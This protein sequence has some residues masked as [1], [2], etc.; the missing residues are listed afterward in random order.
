MDFTLESKLK[1]G[2][3]LPVPAKRQQKTIDNKATSRSSKAGLQFPVG[4]VHRH[5]KNGRYAARIGSSA[6]V[7]LAA[8]LEYLT[9]DILE[10]ADASRD[11]KAKRI[12]PRH[13]QLAVRHD[14][15]LGKILEH[16]TIR[17]GGVLPNLH[18][19][20]RPK[21][22]SATSDLPEQPVQQSQIKKRK[23]AS[24]NASTEDAAQTKELEVTK[25]KKETTVRAQ[26][27]PKKETKAMKNAESNDSYKGNAVKIYDAYDRQY[28]FPKWQ[29]DVTHEH[30]YAWLTDNTKTTLWYKGNEEYAEQLLH[31]REP[32]NI[33]MR[34]HYNDD[35]MWENF[36]YANGVYQNIQYRE[37]AKI[38]VSCVA[39][40]QYHGEYLSVNVIN[41]I[42]LAL[43]DKQQPD[44]T[45]LMEQGKDD[46]EQI[47]RDH[48][49]TMW[50]F[51]FQDATQ[52]KLTRIVY[53]HV[54]GG[55]FSKLIN[56]VLED[57]EI[58]F[59]EGILL[60][61]L[62]KVKAKKEAYSGIELVD[63][64]KAKKWIPPAIFDNSKNGERGH[65]GNT[66]YVNAWD[67]WSIVGN[68]NG[69]DDS[70]DGFWGRS[71]D[72]AMRCWPMA[73]PNIDVCK[74][75]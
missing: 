13:I 55:A 70:L 8:V 5:L 75:K 71:S 12:T 6:P 28:A 16:V 36:Q 65:I 29:I 43:D 32:V 15:E 3:V 7:F 57:D 20:L 18:T 68:G 39:Q 74:L 60:P 52:R 22:T 38:A 50:E 61:E 2:T 24:S 30:S 11:N 49:S 37:D 42:G 21:K 35:K 67:P 59:V 40:V 19:E 62:S 14:E 10:L 46:R 17:D 73:N 51:A 63:G 34:R 23:I 41:L 25:K 58:D 4:R 56:T 1:P 66:L 45:D 9:A 26:S 31:Y 53:Y 48:Y 64:S 54:G 33:E 27:Q 69:A 72:M 44:F 47:I